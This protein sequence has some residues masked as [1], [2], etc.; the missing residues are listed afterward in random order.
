MK[1]WTSSPDRRSAAPSPE[2]P[3][4][5]RRFRYQNTPPRD[6][7]PQVTPFKLRDIAMREMR[8]SY[9]IPDFVQLLYQIKVNGNGTV[10]VPP[11]YNCGILLLVEIKKASETFDIVSVLN[12]TDKQAHHAFASYPR[13]KSFGC[14]IAFGDCW[15]YRE[16]NRMDMRE[17]PTLSEDLDSVYMDSDAGSRL[18]AQSTIVPSVEQAYRQGFARL[19]TQDSYDAFRVVKNRLGAI[20]EQMFRTSR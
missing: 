15:A 8:R 1:S 10:N 12:Q 20:A 18:H 2:S 7:S 13:V 17:S 9:Q 6:S 19:Q 3:K 16:Y 5:N 4:N 14:I 11:I